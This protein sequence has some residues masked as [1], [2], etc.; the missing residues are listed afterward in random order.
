MSYPTYSQVSVSGNSSTVWR[1][2]RLIELRF[3]GA[4]AAPSNKGMQLTI[5]SVTPFARAKGAPLLLAADP[6]R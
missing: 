2:G 5:K 4:N 3:V 6:R 1:H